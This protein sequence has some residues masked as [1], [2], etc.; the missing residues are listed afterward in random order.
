MGPTAQSALGAASLVLQNPDGCFSP[1]LIC[2][3]KLWAG[4]SCCEL[5]SLEAV[6]DTKLK[7][8]LLETGLT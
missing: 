2:S 1:S 3:A 4:F 5:S 8:F 7:T 6:V